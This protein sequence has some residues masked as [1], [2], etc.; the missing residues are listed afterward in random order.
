MNVC[1]YIYENGL[2]CLSEFVSLCVRE[3]EGVCVCLSE[4]VWKRESLCVNKWCN[5]YCR[6]KWTRWHEFK[7]WP[8]LIAFHI[9]LIP[10]GKVW[11]QLFPLQLWVNSRADCSS[12]LVRQLV[13]EEEN[14]EFKPVK[15]RLKNWPCVI[16]CLSGGFGKYGKWIWVREG[17]CVWVSLCKEGRERERELFWSGSVREKEGV[18]V[19]L[20]V[21]VFEK[22][23]LCALEFV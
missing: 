13:Q 23:T 18:C 11:I 1:V 5:G 2:M 8:R 9:A 15:L 21:S 10:L 17:K 7:S 6:R 12:A 19:Y 16:Y 3:K 20:S 14:S 22:E 4:S